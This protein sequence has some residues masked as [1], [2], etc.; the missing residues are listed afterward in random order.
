MSELYPIFLNLKGRLCIVVGGGNV[1]LRK[2]RALAA[3]GA[4]LRIVAPDI[5]EEIRSEFGDAHEIIER[6]FE[7]SDLNG[8]LIAVAATDDREL[9]S[10]ISADCRERGILVNAVDQPEDCDFY[11]PACIIAGGIYIAVSTIGHSPALAGWVKREIEKALSPKLADGLEIIS[12]AR[13]TLIDADPDGSA[14]RGKAFAEFFK[15]ELWRE[16]L[17]GTRELIVEEVVE[18]I[19][20]Y[21]D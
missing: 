12:K 13:R 14:H 5:C 17:D 16:F 1:A 9:N 18:W 20:S 3:S 10:R 11:V 15:S 4:K 2:A 6:E 21:T 19:S 7:Q 8:C